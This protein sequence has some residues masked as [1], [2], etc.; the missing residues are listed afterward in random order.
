MGRHSRE[1]NFL[2]KTTHLPKEKVRRFNKK[3]AKTIS[4]L[5][6]ACVAGADQYI[7]LGSRSTRMH[8][9]RSIATA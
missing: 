2:H 1:K 9:F 5:P 3:F 4:L 7:A 8:S 6:R